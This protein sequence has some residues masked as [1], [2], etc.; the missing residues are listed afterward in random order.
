MILALDVGN[1][2]VVLGCIQ[3]DELIFESRIS[4]DLSKTEY[5]YAV[6]FKNILEMGNIN[7]NEIDGCVLSSVV[8]PLVT[9][10]KKTLKII[11]GLSPMVLVS[12]LKTGLNIKLDNPAQL[13]SDQVA[14]AVAAINEY[15]LPAVIFDIGT[16]TTVSVID[17]NANYLGGMILPGVKI[18]QEALSSR[19]SQLPK[20]SLEPPKNTIGKNTVDCMKSGAIYGNAAMIDGIIDI[21]EKELGQSAT[22]IATGGLSDSIVP[23]C[24]HKIIID[25]GLLLKG[26]KIIY[27]KN[28]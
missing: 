12:G 9:I 22:A 17:K 10:L 2:N 19:T 3:N 11:C 13:G 5:Q 21:M 6:E 28:K 18:S 26:L 23:Y 8:P 4:T 27:D 14:D 24:N 15:P 1:T 20:I 25:N 16:A 7:I